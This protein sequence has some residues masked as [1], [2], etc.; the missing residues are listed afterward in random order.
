MV[1]LPLGTLR[2]GLTVT[3]PAELTIVVARR[4]RISLL[5]PPPV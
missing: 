4:L 3:W 1:M 2:A 5:Q